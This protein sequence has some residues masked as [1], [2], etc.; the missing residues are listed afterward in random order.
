MKASRQHFN[1]Q[2]ARQGSVLL[3]VLIVVMLLSFSL[4]SFSELM[5]VQYEATRSSLTHLQLRQLAESGIVASSDL[6]STR[7][8]SERPNVAN[9][10]D[11]FRHVRVTTIDDSSAMYSV[12][13]RLP[14]RDKKPVFGL[15]D[16]S[17]RLNINGL[18]L[19]SEDRAAARQRL[20]RLP[21][22]TEHIADA[23]LDWM[24][25]DDEPSD[26][27]AESSW[28]ASQHPPYRPRQG[29]FESLHELLLVRGVTAELLFG[30]DLN[31]NGLLDLNEDDGSN[32]SPSD[33][34]DGRLQA[35]WSDFLTIHSAESTYAPDGSRKLNVN[36]SELS[37]LYDDLEAKF[38]QET[39]RYVVALRMNG[40]AENSSPNQE[41]DEEAKRQERLSSARRRIAEQLGSGDDNK[42]GLSA[43]AT[44]DSV[45]TQRRGG[46]LLSSKPVFRIESLVDLVGGAV[47]VD[48]DGVDTLL[49]SPWAGDA[50]SVAAALR[51]L[52]PYL[53]TTSRTR[54]RGRINF[55]EAPYEVLMTVPEMTESFARAIVS[56][57]PRRFAT[58][59]STNETTSPAA[60]TSAWLMAQGI[61]DLQ[62]LRSI[63]PY[64]TPRGDVFRGFAVGH[65]DGVRGRSGIRF[66]IDATYEEPRIISLQD[67]PPMPL[68]IGRDDSPEFR[69]R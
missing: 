40:R 6:L 22:M 29:R 60:E 12:L 31:Q 54:W 37:K 4:Y 39:A 65:I 26:Y 17:S 49:P 18:P 16:E 28:Y 21:R 50:G 47:R 66:L 69:T 48:V 41:L 42:G 61:L 46:I 58:S 67:L 51:E 57:R 55:F 19:N 23:I 43:M 27:G 33:N 56:V 25:S 68:R 52:L 53:T 59:F 35:G 30:E 8:D 32:R 1:D 9:N 64:V 15:S 45:S 13:S 10:P 2:N 36:T 11:R 63:A 5:L 3:L 20:T 14:D 62:R 24:D 44:S 38:D 7:S 34:S